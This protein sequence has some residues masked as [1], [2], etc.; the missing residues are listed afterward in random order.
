MLKGIAYLN[1]ALAGPPPLRV[2]NAMVQSVQEWSRRGLLWDDSIGD[3]V[4]IKEGF[5]KLIGTDVRDIAIVPSVSAGLIAVASSLDLTGKRKRAVVSSLN[6][7]ANKVIWQRMKA[8][9][10]LSDIRLLEAINGE[11]P[12]ESYEDAV[13]DS[14]ALVAVDY[15][16]GF[17]GFVERLREVSKIAHSHGAILIVDAFHAV[18]ALPVSAK[19]LG[20][21][22]LLA[23]FSKWMCGPPGAACLFV[24]GKLLEKLDP[25]Y[26]GWQG[27]NGNIIERKLS[28]RGLF[29][30]PFQSTP[31]NT[32]ARFEWG[33]WSPVVL[34]G[35][36]ESIRFILDSNLNYRYSTIKQ[37]K[38]QLVEGLRKL[39]IEIIT[40]KESIIKGGGIVAFKIAKEKEFAKKLAAKNVIVAANF[41]RVVVSPHFYNS[42]EDIDRFLE[43]T[44]AYNRG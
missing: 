24:D 3:I 41:G 7:S 36:R 22:V 14:T 25:S 37:R 32:A 28:G 31:S 42:G 26:I 33:T 17:N 9:G 13:E 34:K 35:V 1:N 19:K 15:V 21:D 10:L 8:R 23:G 5:A 4:A 11:V 18:S 43:L 20:I 39:D 30:T 38:R 27:I 6:F 16:S 44:K 12:I 29:D 40:P 2:T